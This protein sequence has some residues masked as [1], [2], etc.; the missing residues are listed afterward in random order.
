MLA[1]VKDERTFVYG[2]RVR[3]CVNGIATFTAGAALDVWLF[4]STPSTVMQVVTAL[5]GVFFAVMAVTMTRWLVRR[6]RGTIRVV[7]AP[8]ALRAPV[9]FA[10]VGELVE[11]SYAKVQ[12]VAVSPGPKGALQVVHAGGTLEVPRMMLGSDAQFD[13]LVALVKKRTRR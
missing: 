5:F 4:A 1:A 7:L 12:S 3:H 13:E 8:H 11:I 6:R 2:F 10:R 9:A